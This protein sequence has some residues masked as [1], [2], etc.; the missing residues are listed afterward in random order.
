MHPKSLFTILASLAVL[1]CLTY[2]QSAL[3]QHRDPGREFWSR[4][5]GHPYQTS[6][7]NVAMWRVVGKA[8]PDEC[9]FGVGNKDNL[10]SFN[11]Y[12]GTGKDLPSGYARSCSYG[13]STGGTPKVN[14]AY[15][16]GMTKWNERYIWF[17]TIANT[18]CQVISA[19]ESVDGV[20]PSP[21][22]E[23]T[24]VCEA[25]SNGN[26][27]QRPPRIFMFDTAINRLQDMTP[28][29]KNYTGD[30]GA[31]WARLQQTVGLRSAGSLGNMV[32]LAGLSGNIL[33]PG[34]VMFAFNAK[35]QTFLGSIVFNGTDPVPYAGVPT[36]STNP[37]NVA[38]FSNIRQWI[39]AQNHLYVGVATGASAGFG[40]AS[41]AIL[42]WTGSLTQ[43]FSFDV[44][45]TVG[46]DPAYLVY[47][48][49]RI[50]VNT[51]GTAA[52]NGQNYPLGSLGQAL[53]MGPKF[54]STSGTLQTSNA[55]WGPPI[56]T[57]ANYEPEPS[58]AMDGGAMEVFNGDIYF[59]T[60]TPPGTQIIQFSKLY[61]GAPTDQLSQAEAFL[62]SYR[63]TAMFRAS[64][65]DSPNGPKFEL[66]YGNPLLPQFVA[67]D[68]TACPTGAANA[69][70]QSNC[71]WAM[72]RNKMDQDPLYGF[73]GYN[74]IFNSYTWWMHV[75]KGQLLVGTFDWSYLA[76]ELLFDKYGSH[77]P[78]EVITAARQ[79]EGAD[80]L[81]IPDPYSAAIPI[82][83]DGMGNFSNYG[84][85][86]MIT[87]GNDLYIGTANPF[88]LLTNPNDNS[89][90]G[91]LGGWELIDL[92]PTQ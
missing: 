22:R 86:N 90:E 6:P 7:D 34:V 50:F 46:A 89:Y 13:S 72:T 15:L 18:L 91:R 14:Q 49:N 62:G 40:G 82:S 58:A 57:Y 27:D 78:P 68:G 2:P 77:I 80:L 47:A 35:Q 20:A 12:F 5:Y 65:L 24:M 63:P 53:Y 59:T 55:S 54:D 8:R 37:A 83:L 69:A 9:F 52:L 81:R 71:S 1:A 76:Y 92:Q 30:S 44:V 51:W 10:N 43:P 41:G 48:H 19:L 84:I 60:M 21:L 25:G 67:S 32:I 3:A 64:H 42:R 31:S 23:N 28:L 26:T 17:G 11:A 36:N 45:G 66:L 85:R 73:G 29:V 74:N 39:V 75:Y 70:T 79:F 33:K 61:P 16:W 38:F 88:N 4:Y 87:V 56:F